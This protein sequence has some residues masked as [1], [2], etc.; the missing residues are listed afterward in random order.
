[1]AVMP[2]VTMW[3]GNH[4]CV[5]RLRCFHCDMIHANCQRHS[6]ANSESKNVN[7]W[8]AEYKRHTLHNLLVRCPL[9]TSKNFVMKMKFDPVDKMLCDIYYINV[10]K[11][12]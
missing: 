9:F 1:M 7:V 10:K 6:L 3:F 11:L 12:P 5:N 8:N 2:A 4:I